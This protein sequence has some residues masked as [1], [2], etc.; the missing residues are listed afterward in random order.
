M[1]L[2]Y[3][4]VTNLTS[5]PVPGVYNAEQHTIPLGLIESEDAAAAAAGA[6]DI[7]KWIS[8]DLQNY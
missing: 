8:A 2:V 3:I 5:N 1:V 4:N 7:C 6:M